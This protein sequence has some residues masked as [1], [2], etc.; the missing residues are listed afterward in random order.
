MALMTRS[1]APHRS[2]PCRAPRP[3]R[4]ARCARRSAARPCPRLRSAPAWRRNRRPCAWACRRRDRRSSR[5][6]RDRLAQARAR[7]R[8]SASTRREIGWIDDRHRRFEM[9]ELAQFLGG[10]RDLVRPAA[11]EDGD[12]ADR[13]CSRA[14][15]AHGRRCPILRT[16]RG[17]WTGCA[18]SR[19]R[20]CRCRSPP[21][22]LPPSGGS[23]SAKSGW[24]LYQ[25]TNSAEPTTPGRSSPGMPSLRSCGAPVARITAS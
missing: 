7:A 17:S 16:R 1:P 8:S 23:R 12:G 25:P 18:R 2:R 20:H 21:R 11:A 15:R 13:R 4:R 24:P 3:S 6:M 14:R 5:R 22:A 19:A 9:A 10:H